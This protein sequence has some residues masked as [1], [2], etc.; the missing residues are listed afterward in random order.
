MAEQS[1]SS[2]CE[3]PVDEQPEFSDY[4]FLKSFES[5]D[6]FPVSVPLVRYAAMKTHTDEPKSIQSPLVVSRKFS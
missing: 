3:S 2:S 4:H 6:K 1:D 5:E